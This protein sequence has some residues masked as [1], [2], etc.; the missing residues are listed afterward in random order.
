MVCAKL[1]L[2]A[3]RARARHRL[4][5]GQLRYPRR[6]P[7][8]RRGRRASRCRSRR[9]GSRAGG[10]RTA[11][12]GDRVEIRVMDYRDLAGERFD[13][14]ASIGMVEHV[15]A[16]RDRPLRPAPRRGCCRRAGGCSTTASPGCATPTPRPGRSRSATSSRTPSRCTSRASSL[17][18]ERA[19][20]RDRRTSR[21]SPTTTPRRSATGPGASTTTSS[22][23]L[24]SPARSGCASGGSTCA[25]PATASRPASRRSTRCSPARPEPKAPGDEFQARR[26]S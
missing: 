19:G 6:D 7:P 15:G 21:A 24:G 4:R 12:V 8:R 11:G 2:A 26:A 25:P 18:L 22:E 5:L 16:E 17:A 23:A 20:L 13:A 1:A 10:S 14:I 9:R 3:R